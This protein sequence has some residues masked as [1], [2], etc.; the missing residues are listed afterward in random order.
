MTTPG[1]ANS[2]LLL[3]YAIEEICKEALGPDGV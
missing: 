2:K 3:M 1:Y